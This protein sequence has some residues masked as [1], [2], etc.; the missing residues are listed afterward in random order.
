M[1]STCEDDRA[2]EQVSQTGCA[3]FYSGDIQNLLDTIVSDMLQATLLDD[4]Q[5]ALSAFLMLW[6][7]DSVMEYNPKHR[8]YSSHFKS[9]LNTYL[10]DYFQCL[11]TFNDLELSQFFYSI[12]LIACIWRNSFITCSNLRRQSLPGL[13]TFVFLDKY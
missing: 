5:W 3:V 12:F 8:F 7:C 1:T 6:F 11:G 13:H 9:Q 2:V 10:V 4:I